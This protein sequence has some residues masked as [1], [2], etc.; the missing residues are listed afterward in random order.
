MQYLYDA[1][2]QYTESNRQIQLDTPLPAFQS[3]PSWPLLRVSRIPW[4]MQLENTY[5][6]DHDR[7][8]HHRR[9]RLQSS[10][11]EHVSKI[12]QRV[13]HVR[14]C[15]MDDVCTMLHD[16][17]SPPSHFQVSLSPT[18]LC[19]TQHRGPTVHRP[20]RF[21]SVRETLTSDPKQFPFLEALI[22]ARRL[23]PVPFGSSSPSIHLP[24][25]I[26]FIPGLD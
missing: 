26:S 19:N 17:M 16:T 1:A 11:L 2:I 12:P 7:R 8:R 3:A 22:S 13:D 24:S 14:C 5:H 6:D 25:H 15:M 18:P 20:L 10:T 9:P 21:P 4:K 23:P